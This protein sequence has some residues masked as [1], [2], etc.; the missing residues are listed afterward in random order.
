MDD[1]MVA[2]LALLLPVGASEV[3]DQRLA[4]LDAEFDERL[5]F[6]CAPAPCHPTALPLSR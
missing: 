6:R 2:N 4:Q 1:R 5:N 3:L